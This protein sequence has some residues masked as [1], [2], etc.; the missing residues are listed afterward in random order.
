V[1]TADK[2]IRMAKMR[3]GIEIPIIPEDFIVSKE[4]PHPNAPQ[5]SLLC[6]KRGFPDGLDLEDRIITEI[7]FDC[8]PGK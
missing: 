4:E 3:E 7:L 5:S 8:C 2:E 6:V 1:S